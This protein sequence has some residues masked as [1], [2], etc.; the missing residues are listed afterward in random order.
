MEVYKLSEKQFKT[1]TIKMLCKLKKMKQEQ[2]E[3]TNK[4]TESIENR[5]FGAEEYN[6]W[7]EKVI[8]GV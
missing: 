8:R 1:T 3:N 4:E 5:H 7:T 2:N 6:N